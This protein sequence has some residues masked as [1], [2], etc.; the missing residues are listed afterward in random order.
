MPY[1]SEK[2]RL[3]P[4]QDRRRKLSE[5]QKEEIRK[6]YATGGIGERAL[7]KQYGVSKSLIHITI[8]QEAAEKVQRRVKEHWR[9]YHDRKKLTEAARNL[10]SYKQDLY[11]KGE[12]KEEKDSE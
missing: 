12:L 6:I 8:N 7:A 1:K 11:L 4:S 5:E 2:I 3:S 10:R 9:D